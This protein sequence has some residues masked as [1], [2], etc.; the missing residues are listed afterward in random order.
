MSVVEL[1]RRALAATR[2]RSTAMPADPPTTAAVLAPATRPTMTSVVLQEGRQGHT[3][4]CHLT[5]RQL[6]GRRLPCGLVVDLHGPT[7]GNVH[8]HDD[9]AL[10][11]NNNNKKK[12]KKKNNNNNNNKCSKNFDVRLH[13]NL[14]TSRGCEHFVL[15]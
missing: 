13:R 12:K 11:D 7:T 5:H 2:A 14:V 1:H 8:S 4:D 10:T 15:F 3:V 9:T 6:G